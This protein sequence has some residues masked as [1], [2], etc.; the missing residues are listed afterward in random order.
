M[1]WRSVGP[2][3]W[4]GGRLRPARVPVPSAPVTDA[5]RWRGGP[6][7]LRIIVVII[8]LSPFPL[9][10][11]AAS[12]AAAAATAVAAAAA[13]AAAALLQLILLALFLR[14]GDRRALTEA[15]APRLLAFV[16][17]LRNCLVELQLIA[18]G[19]L[20][21]EREDIVIVILCVV[22]LA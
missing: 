22:L 12:P 15:L 11:Y 21:E 5:L 6:S 14:E 13:A 1:P 9:L 18:I 3:G 2:S 16:L 4:V 17:P 8:I 19:P 10:S 7:P 20:P